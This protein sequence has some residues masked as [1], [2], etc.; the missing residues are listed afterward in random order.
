[1][2]IRFLIVDPRTDEFIDELQEALERAGAETLVARHVADALSAL[3][4]F[5]FDAVLVGEP[6]KPESLQTL[7]DASGL[8]VV[9]YTGRKVAKIVQAA[10][11]ATGHGQSR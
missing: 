10:M 11:Q 6:G 2:L 7:R 9:P 4:R 8:P 1:M 3:R 5:G